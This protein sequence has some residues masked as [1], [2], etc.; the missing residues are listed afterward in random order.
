MRW[1]IKLA[2]IGG[3][4]LKIHLTFL[5]FLVWIGFTYYAVGGPALARQ[6]VVFIVLLFACVL[7]HEL[8]HALTARAFGIRTPDITLLPIGGVAR[9]ERI[10]RDPKQELLIAIAGPLVNV[11]IALVLILALNVHASFSD[12][13]D[14]NTPRVALLQKLAT[15]NI[16]LAL[17]NLIPAFPMD[18]GRVLRAILAM[19][20]DYAWATQV[21]ARVGQ[22]VAFIFGLVGLFY[23][24][25]LIFIALFVYLGATQEAS[26]AQIKDVSAGLPVAEAMVTRVETL[27]ANATI[28]QASELLL[29]TSQ[30]EFPVIDEERH[31]L[32]I[33]ARDDLIAAVRQ[34]GGDTLVSEVMRRDLPAVRPEDHLDEAFAKMQECGYPVLPVVDASG[35]LVGL[36]TTENVGEMM[37]MKSVRTKGGR[38]SRRPA[39]AQG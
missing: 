14:V 24:P 39:H 19:R 10:P 9:M 30:H 11:V 27:P 5:I 3:I 29:R 8:G 21:A 13:G 33:L 2:R 17:F 36:L 15:V 28:E 34:R 23:N 31:V 1:S 6:G 4:E 7:L 12:L 18:G 35:R 25:L 16:F 38:A 26:L 20:M 22:G 32:G 37:V